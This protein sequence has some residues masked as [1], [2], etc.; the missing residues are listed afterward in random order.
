MRKFYALI[1]TCFFISIGH[2]Q[3][4]GNEWINYDQK[5]YAINVVQSGIY[6]VDYNTLAS[7]GVPLSTFSPEKMHKAGSGS[8]VHPFGSG[9]AADFFSL[10]SV[11]SS[12]MH[13]L[14]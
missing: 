8:S 4:F 6:K 5:Y 1:F 3:T 2:S 9:L 13:R 7:S 12:W 14:L 11:N 10:A